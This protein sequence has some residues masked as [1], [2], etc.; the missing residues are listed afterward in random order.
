MQI[1]RQKTLGKSY[2]SPFCKQINMSMSVSAL[3]LSAEQLHFFCTICPCARYNLLCYLL[4]NL[5]LLSILHSRHLLFYVA[6]SLPSSFL[7][8]SISF[9]LLGYRIL[10]LP[11]FTLYTYIVK[12]I[13]AQ[14][15]ERQP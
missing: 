10:R 12:N 5:F 4:V 1:F 2:F 13:A 9:A 15:A 7:I 8:Y 6:N 14:A 3:F 11:I